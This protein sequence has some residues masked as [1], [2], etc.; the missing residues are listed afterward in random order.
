MA[1]DSIGLL[2]TMASFPIPACYCYHDWLHVIPLYLYMSISKCDAEGTES[3]HSSILSGFFNVRRTASH[4]ESIFL[5][6]SPSLSVPDSCRRMIDHPQ[7]YFHFKIECI[8]RRN[9]ISIGPI[10]IDL[11]GFR[12]SRCESSMLGLSLSLRRSFL[13][14][15]D[16]KGRWDLIQLIE[17]ISMG[18]LCAPFICLFLLMYFV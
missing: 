9:T 7:V 2:Y 8:T 3:T 18:C 15:P 4:I 12:T 16:R 1:F 11:S 17:C 13:S 14:F 5:S 10:T 6:F